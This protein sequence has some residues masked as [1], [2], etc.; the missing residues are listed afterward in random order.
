MESV[1]NQPF[2]FVIVAVA[3]AAII[4]VAAYFILRSLK[5]S[6]EIQLGSETVEAGQPLLCSLVV[7]ARKD[8]DTDRLYAALIG[9]RQVRQR[10]NKGQTTTRWVE[11]YRGEVDILA[12][13]RLRAGAAHTHAFTIEV[14][15]REEADSITEAGFAQLE[16]AMAE[17]GS[18]VAVGIAKGIGKLARAGSRLTRGKRRWKVIGRLETKGVDLAASKKVHVSFSSAR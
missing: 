13:E 5:G 14:P 12:N 1:S 11:F 4:G 6:M 2:F 8:I 17:T 7:N 3:A 15:T 10:N 16:S 9:E 18:D